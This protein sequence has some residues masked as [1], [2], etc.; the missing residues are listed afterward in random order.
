MEESILTS[1]KLYL[2]LTEDY[3]PFDQQIMMSINTALNALT[4]LGIGPREG[5]TIH[6]ASTVWSDWYG[7]DKRMEAAKLAVSIRVRLLFDPPASSTMEETLI[8]QKDEIEWRL[9]ST[10]NHP[11]V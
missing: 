5:F 7:D 11:E 2:G 6:D 9:L 3:T 8:A 10:L 1:V 4:Q